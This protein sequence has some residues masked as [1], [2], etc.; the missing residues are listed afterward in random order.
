M[1]VGGR[2]KKRGGREKGDWEEK[3]RGQLDRVNREEGWTRAENKEGGRE[4]G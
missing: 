2:E 1:R 3:R 4:G